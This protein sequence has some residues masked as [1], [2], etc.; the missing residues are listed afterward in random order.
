MRRRINEHLIPDRRW[1]ATVTRA[2]GFRFTTTIYGRNC[3]EA[4]LR[5]LEEHPGTRAVVVHAEQ[6]IR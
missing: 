5:Y 6:G 4:E 3:S 1:T 2:D